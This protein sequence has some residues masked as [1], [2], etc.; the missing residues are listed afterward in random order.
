MPSTCPPRPNWAALCTRTPW[1][2]ATTC[3]A[4][5]PRTPHPVGAGLLLQPLGLATLDRLGVGHRIRADGARV[6]RLSGLTSPGGRAILDVGYGEIG[7]GLN[8]NYEVPNIGPRI[9]IYTPKGELLARLGRGPA[10]L[11]PGQF[12]S[13]HGLAV[14]SRGD[15]YVGEVSYTNWR[16]RYRDQPPPA[17]LRSL[18]K[19]VKVR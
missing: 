2:F 19:L 4:H 18:Q 9:S 14:D 1:A 15:V 3:S 11:E 12:G 8:V 5:A 6:D 10:G 7:G 16:N 17:G 13:P